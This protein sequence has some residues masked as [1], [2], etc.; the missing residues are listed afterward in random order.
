MFKKVLP[1]LFILPQ[2]LFAQ[3]LCVQVDCKRT[4]QL[5]TDS[6]ALNSKIT[7]SDT[8]KTIKWSGPT[9]VDSLLPV[10]RGLNVP[11]TYIYDLVA[12]TN[13]TTMTA[14]DTIIVLP[15]PTPLPP[16]V[17]ILPTQI[18]VIN[19]TS[20][21]LVAT[22]TDPNGVGITQYGWGKLS[23]AGTQVIVN[24]NKSTCIVT[25]L[26]SGIYQFKVTV[27]NAAGLTAGAVVTFNV[28]QTIKT[29]KKITIEYSDG[30]I[31]TKP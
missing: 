23:G 28:T 31:E 26:K 17:T 25:G 18:N 20:D 16:V 2:T 19:N 29:I 1:L 8:I 5:P 14:Y 7:T 9:K 11:G 15:A 22:A 13:K 4:I 6:I 27:W 12:T 21:T 10:A 3:S 30:T 24:A